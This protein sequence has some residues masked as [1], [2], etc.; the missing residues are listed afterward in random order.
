MAGAETDPLKPNG[1]KHP[2]QPITIAT[3]LRLLRYFASA[4]VHSGVAVHRIVSIATLVEQQN[5]DKGIAY[6]W[7]RAG[8]RRS[9]WLSAVSNELANVA[10]VWVRV[11]PVRYTMMRKVV[12]RLTP[13]VE[14]GI[15]AK[16]R[17]ILRQLD[18]PANVQKLLGLPRLLA[19]IATKTQA[20]KKA[21]FLMQMAVA[22]ELLLVA[23]VR[24][25]SLYCLRLNTHF[26]FAPRKGTRLGR[27]D[28]I[29]PGAK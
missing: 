16:N 24:V 23:P 12:T 19:S 29:I 4:L 20:P 9:K 17:Q 21:A 15:T 5:F 7:K 1:P 3:K 13:P 26:V 10:K 14:P 28:L 2:L 25:G 8:S 6:L 27:V 18:D 11:D 22:I